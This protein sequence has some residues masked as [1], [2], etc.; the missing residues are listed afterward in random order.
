MSSIFEQ[1]DRMWRNI[2]AMFNYP[3]LTGN[4]KFEDHGLK[5]IIKRPHSLITKK[6]DTGKVIAYALDVPY[7][8]FK[9]DEVNVE[10]K[11]NSLVVTC[12]SENKVKDEDMDFNSI[13]YQS[14]TFS[15]PLSDS[16]DV[17]GITATAEDGMLHINLPAKAPEEN[18]LKIEVK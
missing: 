10:V 5:G 6:D 15:I 4:S 13:S 16:V 3:L 14:F 2:D 12:G 11:G 17:S 7:T 8:P 18:T 1:V 9:K